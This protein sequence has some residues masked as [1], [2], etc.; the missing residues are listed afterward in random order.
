MTDSSW[1]ET[2]VITGPCDLVDFE[3]QFVRCLQQG[4]RLF[5][6]RDHTLSD[7]EW[8]LRLQCIRH[9]LKSLSGETVRVLLNGSPEQA[10]SLCLEGV[11]LNSQRLMGLLKRPPSLRWVCGSCHTVAEV[12]QANR[13]GVDFIVISPVL[14]TQSHPQ[15]TP[16]GWQQFAELADSAKMPVYALG[17]LQT[18]HMVQAQQCGA[19]G[20]A[21]IG[22]LWTSTEGLTEHVTHDR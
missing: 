21:A 15:A 16:L 12:K 20:I 13:L 19:I 11:H 9:H 1:S 10:V 18:Q 7:S 6:L 2:Y 14:P 22:S 8:T 3:R 17:G 4:R 5:Q